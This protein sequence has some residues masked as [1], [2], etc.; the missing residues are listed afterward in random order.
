MSLVREF[1]KLNVDEEFKNL[2]PR[3]SDAEFEALSDS[4]DKNGVIDPIMIWK[5]TGIIV[6]G[7][8]R[9]EIC[10]LRETPFATKEM[11]FEDRDAV[12]LWM[13][14]YQLARRT[15][16]HFQRSEL[17]LK[18]KDILSDKAKENQRAG[19]GA[20]PMKSAKPLDTREQMS[21]MASVSQD[22]ISKVERIIR[23]G[24]EKT[25]QS[26]RDG[27]TKIN[28]VYSKINTQNRDTISDRDA[29]E[30]KIRS[31]SRGVESM[32]DKASET[33]LLVPQREM[34]SALITKLIAL[35]DR[36]TNVTPSRV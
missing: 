31:L 3:Q 35:V 27:E 6:D 10:K 28:A 8:H 22:T 25:I 7:H 13:L 32:I 5:G 30:K 12:K 11:E 19:G 18:F 21:I 20:V 33:E 29:L 24:D 36:K 2:I 23:E 17:V 1:R 4:I 16:N 34:L 26:L 9:Y 14:Q 15:L